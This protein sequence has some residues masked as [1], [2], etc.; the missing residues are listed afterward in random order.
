VGA[1]TI[2]I[3]RNEMLDAFNQGDKFV[4]AIAMVGEDDATDGNITFPARSSTATLHSQP[5]RAMQPLR[6]AG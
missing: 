2:T 3:T 4:L 1:S 5:V 6:P